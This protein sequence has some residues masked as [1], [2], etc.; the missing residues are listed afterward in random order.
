M[1][2]GHI[3]GLPKFLG[4]SK[5]SRS[6]TVMILAASNK[7]RLKCEIKCNL[8]KNWNKIKPKIG[9]LKFLAFFK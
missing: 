8:Y 3:Q 1:E 5:L 6:E 7:L 2:R 9:L 4:Y